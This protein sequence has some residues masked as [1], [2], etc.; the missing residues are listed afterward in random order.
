MD[1]LEYLPEHRVFYC[2]PYKIGL[3]PTYYARH[4]YDIHS[5][6]SPKLGS[7][8]TTRLFISNVLLPSL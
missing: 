6:A 8:K 2:K 7:L 3:I 4:L 5:R 1:L